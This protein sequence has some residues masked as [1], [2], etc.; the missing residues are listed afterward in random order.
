M[1]NGTA[2]RGRA[3]RRPASNLVMP[4]WRWSGDKLHAHPRVQRRALLHTPH[5]EIPQAFTLS[6]QISPGP[7]LHI[8]AFESGLEEE[9]RVDDGTARKTHAGGFIHRDGCGLPQLCPNA[10]IGGVIGAEC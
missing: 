2:C 9:W 8:H 6:M 7:L 4:V 10:A 3:R 1:G 5:G